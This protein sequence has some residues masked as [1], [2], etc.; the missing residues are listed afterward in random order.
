MGR[1][2]YGRSSV[3]TS[4]FHVERV[5]IN[6]G[7]YDSGGAYW[8]Q[9]EPLYRYQAESSDLK[10]NYNRCDRCERPW[11]SR[12]CDGSEQSHEHPS[13]VVDSEICDYV[14]AQDRAHAKAL[15]LVQYPAA[16]FYR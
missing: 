7:G 12:Y 11:D 4:K 2:T 8:G 16:K 1:A 5:P 10:Y 14:R 9:D 6:G 15:I 13:K 3:P